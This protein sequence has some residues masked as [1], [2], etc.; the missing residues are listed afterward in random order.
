MGGGALLRLS[1]NQK[2]ADS[3]KTQGSE[4]KWAWG[5]LADTISRKAQ[6]PNQGVVRI[7]GEGSWEGIWNS[8]S[9]LTRIFFSQISRAVPLVSK[10]SA[11]MWPLGR[12]S[13]TNLLKIAT[14]PHPSPATIP[15]VPLMCGP[16][17]EL[18][19][20]VPHCSRTKPSN[21][22][23]RNPH[24]LIPYIFSLHIYFHLP[25]WKQRVFILSSND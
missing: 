6:R 7:W 5:R 22:V 10:H 8:L 16:H 20:S 14:C 25:L 2:C 18:C 23:L 19:N 17:T 13:L 11:Q 1:S 4:G 9:S 12:P 15:Y 21:L 24:F 3:R